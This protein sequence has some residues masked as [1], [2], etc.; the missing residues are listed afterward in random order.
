[1]KCWKFCLHLKWRM[2][3]HAPWSQL[4]SQTDHN[5]HVKAMGSHVCNTYISPIASKIHTPNIFWFSSTVF[6]SNVSAMM[7]TYSTRRQIVAKLTKAPGFNRKT[8]AM[9]IRVP[10]LASDSAADQYLT[11]TNR[12]SMMESKVNIKNDTP[13]SNPQRQTQLT[14]NIQ[15]PTNWTNENPQP[16]LQNE[17]DQSFV[18]SCCVKYNR[19]CTVKGTCGLDATFVKRCNCVH[20]RSRRFTQKNRQMRISTKCAMRLQWFRLIKTLSATTWSKHKKQKT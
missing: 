7:L 9:E 6:N 14:F 2:I 18:K 3:N 5:H 19:I 20:S 16:Q 15:R 11:I 13:R 17:S 1:M 12:N 4:F 8:R 10:G